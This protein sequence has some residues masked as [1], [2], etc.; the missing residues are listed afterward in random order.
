[1]SDNL[2]LETFDP[3]NSSLSTGEEFNDATF[4]IPGAEHIR[5]SDL[6]IPI[7]KLVQAQSKMGGAGEHVGC[8]HN[9]VT[10]DFSATLTVLIIGL[11]QGRVMFPTEFSSDSKPICASDDNKT[12]RAEYASLEIETVTTNLTTNK[13]EI[14]NVKVGP[15]CSACP[16]AQ[17]GKNNEPPAC[18]LVETF[19]LLEKDG[20]PSIIQL[21][22][23]GAKPAAALKTLAVTNGIR[24]TIVLGSR[25]DQ[26]DT[27]NY[28]VPTVTVGQAPD[29]E[30]KRQ[31]IV[32]AKLGNFASR[33]ARKMNDEGASA[34][35]ELSESNMPF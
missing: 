26:G 2:E 34:D 8:Y 18:S 30:W 1:M 10:G 32:I 21:S 24:K 6:Q 7:A 3:N 35:V 9:S 25:Q 4:I 22:R 27:G 31:A 28:Y 11:A 13:K 14:V 29:A 16:F 15:S 23:S 33:A 19:A 17:W 20:I 12:P 5:P